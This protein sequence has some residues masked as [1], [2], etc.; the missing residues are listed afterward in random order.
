V[1]VESYSYHKKKNKKPDNTFR[2]V[3]VPKG[4]KPQDLDYFKNKNYVFILHDTFDLGRENR[5]ATLDC[6]VAFDDVVARGFHLA[7]GGIDVSLKM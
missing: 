2:L 5:R 1:L 3:I 4:T 7:S 6:R